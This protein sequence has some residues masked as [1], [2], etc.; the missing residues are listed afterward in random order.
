MFRKSTCEKCNCTRVYDLSTITV[1][2]NTIKFTHDYSYAGESILRLCEQCTIKY[3]EE[4]HLSILE[5]AVDPECQTYTKT[6]SEGY[7]CGLIAKDE[8]II[9]CSGN[10]EKT[11]CR[12]ITYIKNLPFRRKF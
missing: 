3:L 6:L 4:W 11:I 1:D 2:G 9:R 12:A 5:G 8:L 7:F 10:V